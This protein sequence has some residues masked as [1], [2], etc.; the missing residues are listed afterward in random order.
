[1]NPGTPVGLA[2]TLTVVVG[3]QHMRVAIS[4]QIFY[5]AMPFLGCSGCLGG[6]RTLD[7]LRSTSWRARAKRSPTRCS[8]SA[9]MMTYVGQLDWST[10]SRRHR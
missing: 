8:G 4:G 3:C 2:V 9:G 5:V 6:L 7:A 1:V 10:F